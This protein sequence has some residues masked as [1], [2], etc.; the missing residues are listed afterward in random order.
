MRF[1]LSLLL[2]GALAIGSAQAQA[3]ITIVVNFGAGGSADRMARLVAPVM[4]EALGASVVVK[5]TTGAAGALGAQEV[6]RARP[7]GTTLLLTTTGPM[8]IQ[9]HFRADLPYRLADFAPICLLGDA[10]VMMMAAPVSGLW[11]RARA[12]R[13]AA[14]TTAPPAPAPSRMSSWWRCPS[15]PACR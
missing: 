6:A 2:T 15:A 8:A 10:P 7:D 3:P 9:P 14:S 11:W 5:N 4:S 12:P 13:M 1:L